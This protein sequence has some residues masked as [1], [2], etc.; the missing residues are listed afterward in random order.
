MGWE[1]LLLVLLVLVPAVLQLMAISVYTE[2]LARSIRRAS[3]R[4]PYTTEVELLELGPHPRA[5]SRLLDR[6]T[7]LDTDEID[8]LV[9]R[10][11]GSLPL[12]MSRSAALR[13]ATE[14]QQLGAR[15]ATRYDEPQ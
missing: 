2:R 4:P 10:G 11:G 8:A 9:G 14:L 5:V 6:A 1:I 7:R 13:L 3:D 12:R 15:A